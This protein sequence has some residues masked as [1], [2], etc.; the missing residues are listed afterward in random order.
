[1]P[2]RPTPNSAFAALAIGVASLALLQNLVIPV[3]PMIQ[4]ELGVTAEAASWTM[5]AWLIAAAVATPV[6]GRVGDL[7]GRKRTF[8][9]VLAVGALGDLLAALSPSLEVLIAARVLQGVGGALFPLAF[10]LIRDLMPARRITGAI[11]AMSAIMAIG[12]AAG[13]VLAGP[14]AAAVGWRGLFLVPMAISIVGLVLTALLVGRTGPAARGRIAV[15][16][17]LLLSGWLVALL[18]PLSSGASWGWS[19]PL[20][21]GLFLLA[22]MLFAAWI[23]VELR[24]RQPLVDIRMLLSPAIWPTNVASILVGAAAFGFWGFL[25]Q[26]LEV[27]AATGWGLGLDTQAAGLVLLPLLIGVSA[28]GFV[29]GSLSRV[30]PLRAQLAG[31]GLLMGAAAVAAVLFHEAAWQ[32]AIAGGVF[33]IGIGLS[34]AAAASIIVQSVPAD[35]VG[36]ATGMNANLRTIGSAIGSALTATLVFGGVASASAPPESGFAVAWITTACLALAGGILVAVV[37]PPRR[38]SADSAEARI[39]AEEAVVIAEAP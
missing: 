24:A 12:G 32:L 15:L 16:P 5:T 20:T 26:F 29:T 7:Y 9:A 1:M 37:R 27:T 11:G 25:P 10:G 34:Y 30:V 14:I 35:R 39:A 38:G 28:I 4:H 3:I 13:S 23:V 21:L 17:A 8:L 19:S 33:G 18:V 36:V 6:L 2:R 31:G 22:A